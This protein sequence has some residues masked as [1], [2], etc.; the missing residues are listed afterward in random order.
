MIARSEPLETV[1]P[2]RR[3]SMDALRALV[4][5]GLVFFH[6]ALVFDEGSDFYVKNAETTG[7]TMIIAGV[8][9]V[10]AMPM[11]FLIAGLGAWHSTAK[12]GAGGFAVERL[13]RLGVPLV[14]ATATF[15]PVPQ[16]L[17]LRADP[18][19]TESYLEFLP[20]FFQVRVELD[21]FPFVLQGEHYET[22]H[23][24]F[25]LLL[26]TFSLILAPLVRWLPR[27]RTRRISDAMAGAVRG[28]GVILL[29]AVPL[30]MACALL[31][32]QE[33]YG[34]WHRWT[35]L[36]FFLY[37]FV[38]AGD[39]RF[40]AAMR[41]D[42]RLAAA[43]GLAVFLAGAPAF[44]IAG[45]GTFT[46]LTP[47]AMGARALYGAAGWCWVI[48]ILGLLDRPP[49]G[50]TS[51]AGEHRLSAY[52]APAVL[53]LYILHQPIVVGVAFVVVG[54]HL[55]MPVKYVLLVL[56]SLALT[57][58]AYDLLVRRTRVTRFLFGMRN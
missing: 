30:A 37:G 25:V 47:V 34:G 3:T 24:W 56:I 27:D 38:L 1:R 55:P 36:L 14:F 6:S 18:A 32:L 40:R 29:G 41:R 28:R 21:R 48:A 8:A 10:W 58:A 11:L 33:E 15:L 54:W 13:R 46:E 9:V 26:L 51:S 39:E 42:A 31:G 50:R 49:S 7:A 45:D 20:R 2:E 35:Y 17:R 44:V 12:R 23:L 43:V 57:V 52:L 4:V 53:P 16:W 5:I 19:Y 22:G